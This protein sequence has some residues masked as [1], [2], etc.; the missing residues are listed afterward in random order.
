MT[1]A[2]FLSYLSSKI[3]Y[4]ESPY[5]LL[6]R[7]K[8]LTL[9]YIGLAARGSRFSSS[10]P[11][12]QFIRS[13]GGEGKGTIMGIRELRCSP[14]YAALA[15]GA[16]S[17]SLELDDTYN[18]GSLHPAAA[19]LP[20]AFAVGEVQ[21][22]SGKA[23]L[24][25]VIYGYEVMGRLGKAL[26]PTSM[27]N[28]GFHPTGICGFF[29]AA[30]AAGKLLNLS[31]EQ[32]THAF[33][34]S[35]SQASA[36]MEFLETG[37]WTKRLHPGWAAHGGMVATE[38]AKS[39]FTGPSTI[40]DGKKGLAHAYSDN[41]DLSLL[42]SD[43]SPEHNVVMGTSIKAHACCRYKQG[44]MDL[45]IDIVKANQLRPEDIEQVHVYLVQTALPIVCEPV[46]G[47]RNPQSSV[48]AQFSMPYGAAVAILYQKTLL[49]AYDQGTVDAPQVKEMMQKVYCHHD[50]TLD[51]E[52]PKKWPARVEIVSTKGTFVGSIEYPKGD[53]ENPLSW[54]ELIAKFNYVTEPVYS[55]SQQDEIVHAVQNL[56]RYEDV[57]QI[58]RLF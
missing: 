53:P 30:A 13:A 16:F 15:N 33:G 36:S 25:S 32:Q 47:K 51:L 38:L 39:G 12:L 11:I 10:D 44:P 14:Q 20:T 48:D 52:F 6:D 1:T 21:G 37:A 19:V 8:Y 4:E 49:E 2:E 29:G 35:G 34:I 31:E 40:I 24:E 23:F 56:E 55:K 46:E 50:P 26:N 57:G 43:F 27:Y 18:E 7:A 42:E 17:H 9:D 5:E 58:T 41:Y 45:I 28:R 3:R 54:D 22:A